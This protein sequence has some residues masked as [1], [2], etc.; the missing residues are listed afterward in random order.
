MNCRYL[1]AKYRNFLRDEPGNT[2]EIKT[3]KLKMKN[4]K[5]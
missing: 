5:G 4:E 3:E 1:K 2:R